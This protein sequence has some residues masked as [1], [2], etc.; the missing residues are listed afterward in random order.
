[1]ADFGIASMRASR[2]TRHVTV[3]NQSV[4]TAIYMSP[5]QQRDAASVD[6]RSDI[7]ATGVMLYQMLTG[8]LPLAGYEPPSK[9][10]AGLSPQWDAVV[11]KALQQRPENRFPDMQAF[12]AP[13]EY[14]PDPNRATNSLRLRAWLCR[15]ASPAARRWAV[16]HQ[17]PV[18][19]APLQVGPTLS[20]EL[21]NFS[22]RASGRKP[23]T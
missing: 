6:H 17:L 15:P 7:Y 5:E 2:A 9:V 3:A 22:Y 4:G 14:R 19:K 13:Q 10:V 16:P 21:N 20:R 23:P 8:E 1:M 11:A 12:E 18:N